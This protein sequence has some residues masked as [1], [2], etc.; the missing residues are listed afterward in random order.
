MISIG[1]AAELAG[2]PSASF[3]LLLGERDIPPVRYDEVDYERKWHAIQLLETLSEAI[4]SG[5]SGALAIVHGIQAATRTLVRR[6]STAGPFQ[7]S[8][9][10]ILAPGDVAAARYPAYDMVCRR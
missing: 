7:P 8:F 5:G 4:S 2:D 1:K 3:E 10:D 6:P 9:G